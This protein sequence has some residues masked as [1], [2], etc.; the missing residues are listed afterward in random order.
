FIERMKLQSTVAAAQ[1]AAPPTEEAVVATI[2]VAL[3]GNQTA[4]ARS[5]LKRLLLGE[6]K[7]ALADPVATGLAARAL[8][9]KPTKEEQGMLLAAAVNTSLLR[10]GGT[11]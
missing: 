8:L 7:T 2:V 11:A 9:I 1:A 6:L 5:T 10:P 3:G 4:T